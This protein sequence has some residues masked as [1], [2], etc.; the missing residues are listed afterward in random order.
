MEAKSFGTTLRR[1]RRERK[2]TL[3]ELAGVLGLSIVYVSDIER[4]NR[5]PLRKPQILRL[6]A[7]LGADPAPLLEAAVRERGIT[8]YDITKTPPLEAEVVQKLINSLICG[9]I[10]DTKLV[11]I[12]SVLRSQGPEGVTQGG[13]N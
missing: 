3:R 9:S 1:I 7:W 13:G 2:K 5:R 10:S 6:C 4:G 12:Q 8:E 11:Q